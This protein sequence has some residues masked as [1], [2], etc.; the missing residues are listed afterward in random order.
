MAQVGNVVKVIATGETGTVTELSRWSGRLEV[1]VDLGAEEVGFAPS[2]IRVV[3]DLTPAQQKFMEVLNRS[4][5]YGV[6]VGNGRSLR[7]NTA[8]AL[9]RKGLITLTAHASMI[10]GRRT[11][12]YSATL[13]VD[14]TDCVR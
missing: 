2:E 4:A 6:G 5:P 7:L 1:M 8:R 11:W 3:E 13:A 9:K 10:T 14:N 12:D